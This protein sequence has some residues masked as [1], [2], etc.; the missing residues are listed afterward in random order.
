MAGIS[1]HGFVT[2]IVS[3]EEDFINAFNW[4]YGVTYYSGL[5]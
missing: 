3:I 2:C 1:L 4:Q 5:I